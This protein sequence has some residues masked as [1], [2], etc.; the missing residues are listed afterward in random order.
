MKKQILIFALLFASLVGFSQTTTI[1]D[2]TKKITVDTSITI[3]TINKGP[4][5][6][7]WSAASQAG[8]TTTIT[9]WENTDKLLTLYH[10]YPNMPSYT[11]T[12]TTDISG[13]FRDPDGT[14]ASYLKVIIDLETGKTITGFVLTLTQL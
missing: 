5:A 1:M 10:T 2:G 13:C 8:T 7:A 3:R 9:L 4:F 6:L 11:L 12:G 14:Q